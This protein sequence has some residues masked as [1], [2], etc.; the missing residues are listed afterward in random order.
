MAYS[1]EKFKKEVFSK[2]PLRNE[3]PLPED[4]LHIEMLERFR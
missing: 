1:E 4:W 3:P 2:I